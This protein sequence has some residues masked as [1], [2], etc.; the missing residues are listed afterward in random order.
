MEKYGLNR[1]IKIF[2]RFP[3]RHNRMLSGSDG[4]GVEDTQIRRRKRH[5]RAIFIL[6]VNRGK[7]KTIKYANSV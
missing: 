1:E 2:K 4:G 7:Q 6:H 3:S 5:G